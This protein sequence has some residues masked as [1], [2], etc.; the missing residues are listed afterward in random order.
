MAKSKSNIRKGTATI[1]R[2]KGP[3]LGILVRKAED[4]KQIK[5]LQT[6]STQHDLIDPPYPGEALL[7]LLESNPVFSACV[8]QIARDVAGLGWQLQLK[9]GA[10]EDAEE[11]KRLTSFLKDINPEH[12][13]RVL[14]KELIEDW[15]STGFYGIEV[16]RNVAGGPGKLFR[17]PAHTLRIHKSKKKFCQVRDE[18]KVWF[19]RF[20]VE[21]NISATTGEAGDFGDDNANELI[22]YRNTYQ[23]SDYYGIPNVISALGDLVG[24]ISSRDYNISFFANHGMP[25]EVVILKGDWEPE[26][27]TTVKKFFATE[28]K[29]SENA[30]KTLVLEQPGGC[31]IDFNPIEVPSFRDSSFRLYEADRKEMILIAYSMPPERVGVRVVGKLGGNVAKEAT[32]IYKNGVIDPLQEDVEDIINKLLS[33]SV[34]DFKFKAIDIRDRDALVN[35]LVGQVTVGILSPNEARNELGREPY[36]GGDEFYTPATSVPASSPDKELEKQMKEF[37]NA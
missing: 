11:K 29:G 36:K 24:L 22:Y 28:T 10:E 1:A 31:E 25:D 18:K 27:V 23:R 3:G 2:G 8:R 5:E 30:H 7:T 17:V 26:A 4:S 6:W 35:S 32:E 16:V 13:L 34:Y 14:V 19:K 12:P 9:E 33:S 37:L 21:G 20:G 15:G